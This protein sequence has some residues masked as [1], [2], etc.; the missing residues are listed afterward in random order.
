MSGA[1]C[2][3]CGETPTMFCNSCKA[4]VTWEQVEEEGVNDET[5]AFVR[6]HWNSRAERESEPKPCPW[7]GR[8]MDKRSEADK[9]NAGHTWYR[10][11]SDYI[12]G[13][14]RSNE[15]MKKERATLGNELNSRAERTCNL[16]E[17]EDL[18]HCSNCGSAAAKQSWAYWIYCPNCGAKVVGE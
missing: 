7:C 14:I 12:Q 3:I 10:D 4:V 1:T 9:D 16:I 2:F 18:L 6:E 15:F 17:D 13:L 5:R 8:D 11:D